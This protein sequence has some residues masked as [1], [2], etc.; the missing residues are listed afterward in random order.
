M[1]VEQLSIFLENSAGRLATVTHALAKANINLRALSLA[2]TSEFGILRLIVKETA[3][4]KQVLKEAG[5]TVGCTDV[6]AV[7]VKDTPGGLDE[8][9][10]LVT[11]KSVNIEY[12]YAFVQEGGDAATMIFRFEDTEAA[13]AVLQE[14]GVRLLSMNDITG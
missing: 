14:H 1:K 3:K 5:F 4:A 8:I 12:I 11:S 6:V 2:D 7:E 10:Q 9:L 13:I